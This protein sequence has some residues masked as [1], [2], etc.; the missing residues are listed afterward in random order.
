MMSVA[1]EDYRN[2]AV[3]KELYSRL[4]DLNSA[5]CSLEEVQRLE[6]KRPSLAEMKRM[7]QKQAA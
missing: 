5:I 1:V 6:A 2:E 7:I 3:L 4:V